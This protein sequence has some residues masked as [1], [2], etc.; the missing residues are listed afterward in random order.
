MLFRSRVLSESGIEGFETKGF[1]G[2]SSVLSFRKMLVQPI[3]PIQA[4]NIYI[5]PNIQVSELLLRRWIPA[6]IYKHNTVK[7]EIAR[8][9]PLYFHTYLYI[10]Y[11]RLKGLLNFKKT[12]KPTPI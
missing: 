8:T 4:L 3:H 6:V 10:G 9:L 1:M 12:E 5:L 11:L 2:F 7:S